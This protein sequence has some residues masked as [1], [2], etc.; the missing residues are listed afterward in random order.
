[1]TQTNFVQSGGATAGAR[2]SG[3]RQYLTF[4]LGGE[5]FAILIE[6]VREII[7]YNGMTTIPMMPPFLRGV[8]NL[9]GKVV[10]VVDLQL[11][12]GRGETVIAKRTCFVIVEIQHADAQHLLGVMVDSVNEVISVDQA[13]LEAKPAFGTKIRSDFVDGILNLGDRFVI[14]L[15]IS[16]ALSIEEMAALIGLTAGGSQEDLQRS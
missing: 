12:F 2:E 9:R 5:F 16:H 3:S 10:P 1:M 8:I 7:E 15:D 13:Q 4:T 14:T 6:H 11:R